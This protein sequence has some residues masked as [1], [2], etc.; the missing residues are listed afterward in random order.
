MKR[1]TLSH[2]SEE[3][4]LMHILGE[5]DPKA[6][7]LIAAHL[8]KCQE[9]QAIL[10]EYRKIL[11][12]IQRWKVDEIPEAAWQLQK[13]RLM[14][15]VRADGRTSFGDIWSR[16]RNILPQTWDY[17]TAHPLPALGYIALALVFASQR[18]ISIFRLDQMLPSAGDV[19]QVI[20]LVL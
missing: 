10:W 7:D 4:L 16:L 13:E 17:A 5:E 12:S 11:E 9:C 3:E 19:I 15:F 2:Y 18:T 14:A 6:S 8:E 20:R 1:P